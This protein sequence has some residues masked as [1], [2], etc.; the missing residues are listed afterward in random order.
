MLT[1]DLGIPRGNATALRDMFASLAG[2]L[3]GEVNTHPMLAGSCS[4]T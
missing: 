4:E 3:E 1:G 2:R